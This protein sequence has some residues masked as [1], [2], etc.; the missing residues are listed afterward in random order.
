M[1][2]IPT[3]MASPLWFLVKIRCHSLCPSFFP[4]FFPRFFFPRFFPQIFR[5]FRLPQVTS[6]SAWPSSWAFPLRRRRWS[7][8]AGRP[9]RRWRAGTRSSRWVFWGAPLKMPWEN[10]RKMPGKWVEMDLSG[11]FMIFYGGPKSDSEMVFGQEKGWRKGWR[12]G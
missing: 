9:R 11:D 8:A 12:F 10:A 2:K 1:A 5:H 3:F 6:F 4:D 7:S